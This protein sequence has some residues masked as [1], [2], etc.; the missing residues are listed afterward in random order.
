MRRRSSTPRLR[1]R[2]DF[3]GGPSVLANTPER[4]DELG[5]WVQEFAVK[6]AL[7][8]SIQITLPLA[9][10]CVSSSFDEGL[11]QR[12]GGRCMSDWGGLSWRALGMTG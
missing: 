7:S 1:R 2:L 8:D 4:P 9:A 5:I 12:D 11:R 6:S 3:G 10:W